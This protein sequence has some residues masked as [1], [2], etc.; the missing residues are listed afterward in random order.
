LQRLQKLVGPALIICALLSA[1][2]YFQTSAP[3]DGPPGWEELILCS[4]LTSIDSK[5]SLSLSEDF[6]A[7]LTESIDGGGSKSSKGHWSLLDAEKHLYQIDIADAVGNYIVVSPPD[8][9][10]CI[11][12]QGGLNNADLRDSWFSVRIDPADY[13]GQP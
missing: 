3:P 11:L 2:F 9:E 5:K 13:E 4:E 1:Y 10:G 8:A 6:S 7:E 12:A